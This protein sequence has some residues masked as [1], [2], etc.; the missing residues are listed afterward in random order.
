MPDAPDNRINLDAGGDRVIYVLEKASPF[1]L[2][3]IPHVSVTPTQIVGRDWGGSLALFGPLLVGILA[4]GTALVW[5][6]DLRD[7][8]S[9]LGVAGLIFGWTSVLPALLLLILWI[10]NRRT[11]EASHDFRLDR[12]A[13]VL[14]LPRAGVELPVGRIRALTIHRRWITHGIRTTIY[15]QVG[16]IA[17]RLAN[18]LGVP[19][20][21]LNP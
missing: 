12:G 18:E 9:R 1:D 17:N 2:P 6:G 21:R 19:V 7:G 8:G 13:L 11:A 5:Y 14:S 16:V 15:R 4:A 3:A 10:G 20:Q